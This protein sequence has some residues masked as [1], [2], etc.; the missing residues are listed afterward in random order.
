M[1]NVFIHVYRFGGQCNSFYHKCCKTPKD[2]GDNTK[3]NTEDNRLN[4][5]HRNP[6]GAGWR[7]T[8]D[9]NNEA[10]FGEF[11]W[12]VAILLVDPVPNHTYVCGASLIHPEVVL[13]AVHCIHK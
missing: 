4:C 5:G 2:P 11:P 3:I 7:I 10:Q 8:G 12:M 13:T 6:Q 9:E 1:Y